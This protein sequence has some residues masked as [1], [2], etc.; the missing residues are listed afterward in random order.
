MLSTLKTWSGWG[1]P[2]D[3]VH[4][5]RSETGEKL[6]PA[7]AKGI[8]DFL[9]Q[10]RTQLHNPRLLGKKLVNAE[11][12]CCRIGGYQILTTLNEDP[13]LIVIVEVAHRREVDGKLETLESGSRSFAPE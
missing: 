6:D 11:F 2:C 5:E 9:E 8:R 1:E 10:N 7:A 12:W 13:I 4:S 3:Q